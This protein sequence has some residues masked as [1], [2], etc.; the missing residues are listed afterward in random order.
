MNAMVLCPGC[1]RHVFAGEA[2][3]P[4]C[5]LGF[6]STTA[7][8]LDI[9]GFGS[10]SA[11]CAPNPNQPQ[12]A[13][14]LSRAQR[15]VVG[16]AIAASVATAGCSSPTVVRNPDEAGNVTVDVN[17][18][19]SDRSSRDSLE[20]ARDPNRDD[21]TLAE[22]EAARRQQEERAR[23]QEEERRRL[24]LQRQ[25]EHEE[26]GNRWR[27]RQCVNGVCPPYGCVF[28]DE[29]CDVVHV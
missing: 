19:Q 4:F 7:R 21:N 24:E 11:P 5:G 14:E 3:C 12:M 10:P 15:Y 20:V 29:A 1:K 25:R 2:A 26:E 8:S 17:D 22:E 6:A 28:P 9:W 16:A 23:R 13:S 18:T 27:H